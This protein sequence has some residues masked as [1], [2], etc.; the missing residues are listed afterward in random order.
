LAL[1]DPRESFLTT[2]EQ[3]HPVMVV[4]HIPVFPQERSDAG[5][6]LGESFCPL[7]LSVNSPVLVSL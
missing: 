7:A 6:E 1:G 2:K 4:V 5:S 3:V